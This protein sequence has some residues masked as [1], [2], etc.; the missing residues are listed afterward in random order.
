MTK[1]LKT[2]PW[3]DPNPQIVPEGSHLWKIT[4][5]QVG[6]HKPDP[7]ETYKVIWVVAANA[8]IVGNHLVL[9]DENGIA[10]M[11]RANG[12]FLEVTPCAWNEHTQSYEPNHQ[13]E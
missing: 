2:G 10:Q 1:L 12:R 13:Y 6:L 11:I 7:E 3:P 8:G 5:K 9:W 4:T